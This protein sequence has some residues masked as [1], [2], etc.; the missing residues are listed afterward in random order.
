MNVGGIGSKVTKR[1]KVFDG[2]KTSDITILTETKF[3]ADQIDSLKQ[4][5]HGMS[6]HSV[7]QSLN[8]RSG[9]SILFKRGL[10]FKPIKEGCDDEGRIVWAE[11]EISTKKLLIIGVYAPSDKDD[12][13]FFEKL[14][15]MLEGR[16]YDHLVI[17]GDFNVGLDENLD[18]LGYS[19]KAPRPKSRSTIARCLKQHGIC[20][21]F[22]ER[23][24]HKVENTWQKRDKHQTK[25]IQ[26]A[27]LDYFLVDSEM[28]SF[29]ELVGAAEPFNPEYDHRAILLKVDFCKVQR[30]AGYWKMNNALLEEPEYIDTVKSIIIRVTH[31]YQAVKPG[32]PLLSKAEIQA[33]TEEERGKIEMSLNPHQF[34]EFLLF[35]IKG[36]TRKYGAKRK[37]NLLDKI[38]QL[39]AELLELKKL[40][41][42]AGQSTVHTGHSY[43][44]AEEK[45]IA[46]ALEQANVKRKE[47]EK[48]E[49]HINQGAYVRTGQHWKCESEQGSKLFFQ[50]EK[51]R[52]DQRYLGI[53]E[54]DAGKDDGSTKLIESQP[55]IEAE[56]HR[57]YKELY[58]HRQAKT[59]REDI[60]EFMGEGY[61]HFENILG[62][63]LPGT[64]QE[65]LQQPISKEEVMQALQ[66]G[67]HGK[68]PGITGFTR[69][70]YQK[71]AESL[72]NP[73]M[74]YIDFA[75]ENGQLSAQQRQGVITLLPKG[76][77]SKLELKNWRPI[78]LLTTLYKIISG[79]IA[80]RVK[81]VL[82]HI[83]G[84]DQKGFVD[85]RY[86]GEVTRT[87]YDTIH[88]AWSNH[89]KGVLL[90]IDFEKAF[91]SLSH[92]F[93][94]QV[95]EV[96][97]FG[98][99]LKKWVKVLLSD[100]SSRVNHV[101][102][103]LPSIDLGR[104]ARQGDP[105]ASLLFVLCIEILLVAIRLNPRIEPYRYHK[106]L[107][108]ES[109]TSKTEAFADDVTL[110]LPYQEKSLREA[111]AM[112]HRFSKI[113]GLTLNQGKTQVM[114]IGRQADKSAKLAPDLGLN[115]VDEIVILGIKLYADPEKMLSNFN[116]K[117]DDIK[118][119]LNRWTFRNLTVYAR[120]QIV[121][122]LG[123]AKLTHVVQI[124]PNPP[125]SIIKDLQKTVNKF[126]WEGGLQKKHVVSEVRAQ[127]PT[128]KGGLG[129][130]NIKDFW[131]GLKGTWIHR[132]N[133]AA[134]TAK[135]KRLA[136]RDLRIAMCK[137]NLNCSNIVIESPQ[138]IAEASTRISN[139]F[140]APIWAK[141][142]QLVNAHYKLMWQPEF[143]AEKVLWGTSNF[144]DEEGEPLDTKNFQPRVVKLFRTVDD[145]IT[146]GK[147]DEEKVGKLTSEKE[148]AQFKEILS[149][150]SCYMVKINQTW[151]GITRSHYGPHHHGWS[152]LLV[153]LKKSKEVYRL[154]QCDKHDGGSRNENELSWKSEPDIQTMSEPRWNSV[155]KSLSL[156]RCNLRIKYEEWRIAWRRQ[157]LNRDKRHYPGCTSQSTKC[158]YC[159]SAVETEN[160][161]YTSCQRLEQFWRDARKWTF[162]EWGIVVPLN[163]KC[164]RIFGME[165]ERP[166]DLFNIFYRNVRYA[167]FKSRETR[168]TPSLDMLEELMLDD[169]KRK[170]A[171]KRVEKYINNVD[172]QLAIAWFRKKVS[173]D[174]ISAIG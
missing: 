129:V 61:A 161:L 115:W 149:A 32:K 2:L 166:D 78:T 111:V 42:I 158:S 43:T 35:S 113:S 7:S 15:G 90:S 38:E 92:D 154:I 84:E 106:V 37:L 143:L 128:S 104:G 72:I 88:D 44:P 4:E 55:E 112:F 60:K 19:N 85:G 87:L 13:A 3:K 77:K 46:E 170:Y 164:N 96:A 159:N 168:V 49:A 145:V 17:S 116:E 27:R 100:F 56:I 18:Y 11:V 137:P 76:I 153:A 99:R 64:V 135:W 20:D 117:V 107:N 93:I 53:L 5:W 75:E 125:V 79:T 110:T 98:S 131:D 126:I 142:P 67:Q 108:Q 147:V 66:K 30:G 83:I 103:L 69:E 45:Q 12:P 89:K 95:M 21:T 68:A 22:R 50:Q 155:Y 31:D 10:A 1:H 26:Q 51:W 165:K 130:P 63:K 59:S 97:G 41:D 156:L 14:F 174:P 48:L 102:N 33:M 25:N 132:L 91:D 24:P 8:A 120:I 173:L 157:E 57:F 122:S 163:L 141:L 58:K 140:W 171:G 62:R 54:V 34:L 114:V 101:G 151:I 94:L 162:L 146:E 123:L 133:A 152:R 82:P 65:K 6:V 169:L 86:M 150:I 47:K 121:K 172:E 127:Q 9:V 119:L 105:I 81:K 52:G 167:I 16:N 136:L 80:E 74:K 148:I 139:Q 118:K 73:I 29:I 39:E 70:F 71:F 124:V 40:T 23:N 144:L 134:D 160:H 138:A 109:I 28:R 36:E